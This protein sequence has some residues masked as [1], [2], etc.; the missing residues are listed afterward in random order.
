[1]SRRRRRGD[2]GARDRE[3]RER[4]RQR[5]RP[6]PQGETP[7]PAL[8]APGKMNALNALE[9]TGAPPEAINSLKIAVQL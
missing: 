9:P 6:A 5:A 8:N 3:P 2:G 7:K 4:K 1:M